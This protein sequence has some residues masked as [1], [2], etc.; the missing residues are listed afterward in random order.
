MGPELWDTGS[1]MET[2]FSLKCRN[3][4]PETE[5]AGLMGRLDNEVKRVNLINTGET[6]P[7]ISPCF[8]ITAF[9]LFT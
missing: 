6:A 5:G 8:G 9:V 2:F 1:P 7:R 3:T 4:R